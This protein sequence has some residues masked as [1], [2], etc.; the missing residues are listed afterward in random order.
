MTEIFHFAFPLTPPWFPSLTR[1]KPLFRCFPTRDG[2]EW[3]KEQKLNKNKK[4][5]EEKCLI[6]FDRQF[7]LSPLSPRSAKSEMKFQLEAKVL[8]VF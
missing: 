1:L 7:S 2:N 8:L 3:S 6:W 4:K 5:K